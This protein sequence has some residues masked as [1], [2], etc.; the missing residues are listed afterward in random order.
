MAAPSWFDDLK[1]TSSPANNLIS[2]PS[3]S[4]MEL[5]ATAALATSAGVGPTATATAADN[6]PMPGAASL[7]GVGTPYVPGLMIEVEEGTG[8]EAALE[9]GAPYWATLRQLLEQRNGATIKV[10][11]E[12]SAATHAQ[13]AREEAARKLITNHVAVLADITNPAPLTQ[14]HLERVPRAHALY[15]DQA[16]IEVAR[17]LLGRRPHVPEAL[18]LDSLVEMKLDPSN[19]EQVNAWKGMAAYIKDRLHSVREDCPNRRPDMSVEAGAAMRTV[20]HEVGAGNSLSGGITP[21]YMLMDGLAAK[22]SSSC[23]LM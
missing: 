16:M 14:T 18:L 21:G 11:V 7:E 23:A 10:K 6:M 20:L 19:P 15:V 9:K 13:K 3:V 5:G 8:M 2:R 1:T 4:A 17:R 12:G 22:P